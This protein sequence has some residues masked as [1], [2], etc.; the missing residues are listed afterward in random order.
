MK[1]AQKMKERAAP[2]LQQRDEFLR[3]FEWTWTKA[4]LFCMV[5]WFLALATLAVIPSWWLYFADQKLHWGP[6]KFWFFKLRDVVAII[7]FSIPMGGFIMA[8]IQAQRLR[9]KLRSESDSRPT[10]GYR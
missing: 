7:L 6:Q 1:L 9:R 4:V 5:M 10:G 8:P 2:M 3:T